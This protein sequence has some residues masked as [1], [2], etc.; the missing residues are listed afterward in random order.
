MNIDKI[1]ASGTASDATATADPR[2]DASPHS[3]EDVRAT[4][5]EHTAHLAG[6][7][8]EEAADLA[9]RARHGRL[10]ELGLDSLTAVRLRFL[11]QRDLD[12]DLTA[13]EVLSQDTLDDLVALV[14]TRAEGRRAAPPSGPPPPLSTE[15]GPYD[16]TDMQRMLAVGASAGMEFTVEP[17]YYAEQERPGLDPERF[18]EA[19]HEALRHRVDSLA[20]LGDDLRLHPL[21]EFTP[22]PVRVHDLRGLTTAEQQRELDRLRERLAGSPLPFDRW[23]WVD[24][25]LSLYGEGQCRLHANMSNFFMDLPSGLSLF[26]DIEACYASPGTD[27][28]PRP[29]GARDAARFLAELAESPLGSRASQYWSRRVETMPGPPDLPR[30]P[31]TGGGNAPGHELRRRQVILSPER[32]EA[33][34]RAARERGLNPVYALLAVYGEIVSGW[35]GSDHFILNNQITR[36]LLLPEEMAEAFGNFSS[37]YPLEFDWRGEAPLGERA[38]ALQ[39]RAREDMEHLHV[40]GVAVLE[41]LNRRRRSPGTAAC[42]FVVAPGLAGTPMPQ[43]SFSRLETPQALADHQFWELPDGGLWIVWDVVEEAFPEG[44]FEDLCTAYETLLN[45]LTDTPR[46]WEEPRL[47]LLPEHTLALRQSLVPVSPVPDRPL[48]SGLRTAATG[49]PR[50]RALVAADGEMDYAGLSR[51]ADRFAERLRLAGVEPGDRVAVVLPKC[52]AQIIAVHGVLARGG[53]YV[54]VDPAWPAER[55]R[56]VLT[57]SGARVAVAESAIDPEDYDGVTVLDPPGPAPGGAHVPSGQTRAPDDLAYI[58]YT[59]GSTGRPKGVAIDHRGPVNTNSDI[60]RR[61]GIGPDD[62]VLG[63]SSLCFD[64]SVYDVFGTADAGATLVLPDPTDWTPQAWLELMLQHRVSV[65]NSAPPLMRLLVHAAQAGGTRLPDLRTVL[66]SGDWI[67]VTLPDQIREIAPHARVISLGGA[68]EA[69]IWSIH[70]PIDEVDPAWTSIPYG[71]PLTNQPWFVLDESGRDCPVW[72]T[73]H[74][75]IGGVGLALGYWGDKE[76]TDAAFVRHPRTGERIYRTGDLGRYLPDGTI[77]LL[78][79]ADFQVKVQGYRVEPGEIEYHLLSDPRVRD[80]AVVAV[81]GTGSDAGKRLAAFVVPRP[82]AEGLDPAA[83]RAALAPK[84]PDYMVPSSLTLIDALP[85]TPNGKLD[86]DALGGLARAEEAERPPFT[87]PRTRL[88]RE[89]A[90]IWEAVLE[91]GPIGAHDDFFAVGGHSFAGLLVVTRVRQTLGAQITLGSLLSER[92]VAGLAALIETSGGGA[93][94]PLVALGEGVSNAPSAQA[95]PS[96]HTEP[97]AL[98]TPARGAPLFVVHPAGG[99][100]LCYRELAELLGRP[101]RGLQAPDPLTGAKVPDRVEEFADVYL[102]ALRAEQP[103][104]P[105]VIA[106]WSSGAVIALELVRRLEEAGEIVERLLVMDAPAPL[107]PGPGGGFDQITLLLWFLE[108]LGAGTGATNAALERRLTSAGSLGERLD[109]L[110]EAVGGVSGQEVDRER[111]GALFTV[112]E[113]V[114]SACWSYRPE[115]VDAGIHLLRADTGRVSEFADHPHG[116]DPDWGWSRLTRGTAS[117][118]PVPGTHHTILAPP[119]VAALANEI[120][121]HLDG[122]PTT[123]PREGGTGA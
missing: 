85:V 26:A 63:V 98:G 109:V 81:S 39:R 110:H 72:T 68:T 100:V 89:L 62:V 42:P 49:S 11:I 103:S 69:S 14:L 83:L 87:A 75:H 52:L 101:S 90:A 27:P 28:A 113:R 50:A 118:S 60:N 15:T 120:N 10:S 57:D 2:H 20:T 6:L 99:N 65:W 45:R 29:Y 71:R 105:Y 21:P 48:H 22:P 59:S 3:A 86:R 111:L 97:S 53:A 38:L 88:E 78:G 40:G 19:V 43:T 117:T 18:R 114:V 104:G 73:G 106:G 30:R 47:E 116:A 61:H 102:A 12:A 8:E 24:F 84:V 55:V 119:H 92:T 64:L 66:L 41:E 122:A 115:P 95:A 121:T 51:A 31:G 54:P 77:E 112:F 9:V 32:W 123:A 5:V 35:S 93:W 108:D 23:P 25:Q 79:R 91:H 96:A 80:A 44:F 82:G 17:H 7:G 56:S 34:G 33:F 36:R 13:Q 94:S 1:H 76:R 70:H 37:M 107:A 16:L 58:I 74:L 67:P 46:L 4:L